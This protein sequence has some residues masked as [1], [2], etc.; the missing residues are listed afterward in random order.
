MTFLSIYIWVDYL[1]EFPRPDQTI[2]ATFEIG[3]PP[4]P[5]DPP[6]DCATFEDPFGVLN[7]GQP[8]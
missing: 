8:S 6:I 7:G 1:L 3:N 5:R 2:D 4:L